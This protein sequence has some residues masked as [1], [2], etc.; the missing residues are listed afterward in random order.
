MR[1]AGSADHWFPAAGQHPD[2]A[3]T[4]YGIE[5]PYF[6]DL[7]LK[8]LDSHPETV[9]RLDKIK[10]VWTDLPDEDE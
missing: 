6:A 1:N 3:P 10:G 9:L 7:E 5:V 4:A 8:A 2:E